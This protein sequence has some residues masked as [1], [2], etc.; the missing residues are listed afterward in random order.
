M[1]NYE[2]HHNSTSRLSSMENYRTD[3]NIC[4]IR[5]GVG[6]GCKICQKLISGGGT[7]IRYSRVRIAKPLG[8]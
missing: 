5:A 7:I 3:P 8:S 1:N 4:H 6:G 2:K